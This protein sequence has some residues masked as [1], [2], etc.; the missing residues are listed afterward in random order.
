M[1]QSVGKP[2]DRVDGRLKVTGG[3]KYSAEMPVANAAYGVMV[4]STIAKGRITGIDSVKAETAPGVIGVMTP[5]NAPR[6]QLP[7]PGGPQGRVLSLLQDNNVFYQ[8]QPLAVV[9]ADTLEH[10]THAASL[11]RLRYDSQKPNV[12]ME[13]G[14]MYKPKQANQDPTDTQRGDMAQ[15]EAQAKAKVSPTYTTAFMNHNPME[16]HATLAVWDAPDQLTVYDATQ[17][18]FGVQG[19]LSKAFNL[20]KDNVRCVSYFIGGGFGCK[21][22]PWSHV[23]LSAMAAKMT[24]RPV[25]LVLTRQQM[26]GPVGYRP[27]TRQKLMLGAAQDGTLTVTRHDSLSNTSQFDEFVEPTAAATRMLYACPNEETSHRLSRIDF[28]TPTYMRAPGESSGTWALEASMD[29]L[30]YALDMDPL[31]LR[32][33]NYAEQDPDENKPFSSKSLRQCYQMAS[34][35]FDWGRRTPKPGSLRAPDGRLM[36]LGMATATY[37]ARRSASSAKTRL[38][39]DGSALVQA[40]TQDIGTGTYTIMTQ[41][42]ADALGLPLSQVRF[43][44]G[45]T[46]MPPTPVSGGSQTAASTGSAVQQACQAARQ[47][48]IMIAVTDMASPLHGLSPNDIDVQDGKMT[49]KTDST[50]SETYSA[51]MTRQQL[52][53]IEAETQ[54]KPGEEKE[55]YS[56]HSFGAI[57]AEVLVDP[58]LGEIRLSRLVGAYDIGRLLNAKTGRSQLIGGIVYGVGMALLEQTVLDER[59]GRVVNPDLAEYHVPVCADIPEIDVSFVDTPDYNFNPIGARGVGEIG[60]TGVVAAIGNAVFHATGVRVRDLPIT[61]DKLI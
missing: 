41:I 39:P 45:D 60:I 14:Q 57:F 26:F 27:T 12:N 24:D 51:L 33:K 17:G 13:H 8:N 37:P 18:V 5:L 9:V 19:V 58:D 40:G 23:V 34:E 50:K 4:M 42:S 36:G 48:A 52:P 1:D 44:L 7:P 56:M 38:M 32:L 46:R 30:A 20:P 29:E 59:L 53:S 16:P 43:E 3:A 28:G 15:G 21:G 10:A 47:K 61:L 35:K 49:S 31:A 55:K 6:V 22:T 2:I 54:S 25:K 11:V